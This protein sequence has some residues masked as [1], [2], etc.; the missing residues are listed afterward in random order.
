MAR[1]AVQELEQQDDLAFNA[2]LYERRC[3]RLRG[4]LDGRR[5]RDR[6]GIL[7]NELAPPQFVDRLI[8]FFRIAWVEQ[9]NNESDSVRDGSAALRRHLV[10]SPVDGN[11]NTRRASNQTCYQNDPR[12]MNSGESPPFLKR[13][14]LWPLSQGIP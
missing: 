12:D 7:G 11:Q 13:R 10:V 6:R 2:L 14:I 1:I 9:E 4:R 8:S 3:D 5:N